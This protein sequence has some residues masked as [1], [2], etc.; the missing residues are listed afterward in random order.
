LL[1][2]DPRD[3]CNRAAQ[4][5]DTVC[6]EKKDVADRV[7][8]TCRCDSQGSGFGECDCPS[9]FKCAEVLNQGDRGVRGS[10]C[11]KSETA[12]D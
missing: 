2:G 10:Y 4:T 8:C 11:V 9:G 1:A 6:A 7:Y 5:G 12:T 3:T